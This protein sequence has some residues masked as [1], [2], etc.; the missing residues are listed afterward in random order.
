MS[1]VTAVTAQNSRE[2]AAV[3]YLPAGLVKAQIEAVLSDY[4][5][6]AA[7]TGFI[8]RAELVETIAV[9]LA[10]Y[11]PLPLVVDPVLVNH[12]GQPMFPAEVIAAY[13]QHL[14]PLADLVTPNWRE[15]ALLA[16]Q[17]ID[18]VPSEA[19]LAAAARVIAA[20]GPRNVLIKGHRA[21]DQ[22]VDLLFDG[23]DVTIFRSP[24]QETQHLHGSGDS[25]S[26]AVCA[27]LARG[28]DMAQAV[29]EAHQYTARAI[30]GAAGWQMG[31][32]H[33]PVS[34]WG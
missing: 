28:L 14:L 1:T 11:R 25:L 18:G 6:A 8:G 5:A 34:P 12:V 7:K 15:A 31:G 32:G 30:R 9:T 16:G 29:A 26:A 19:D 24:W 23:R 2:V 10:P 4:G 21:G 3:H 17:M 20:D 33:G 13:R 22:A 27:F